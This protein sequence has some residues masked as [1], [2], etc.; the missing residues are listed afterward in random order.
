MVFSCQY[1]DEQLRRAEFL[2]DEPGLDACDDIVD[3]RSRFYD[4][5]GYLPKLYDSI[6]FDVP[7][8][9]AAERY[10]MVTQK[11]IK[12]ETDHVF[13]GKLQLLLTHFSAQTPEKTLVLCRKRYDVAQNEDALMT[14]KPRIPCKMTHGDLPQADREASMFGFKHGH[15]P[16]LISSFKLGGRGLNINGVA[17]IIFF[18][19]PESFDEYKLSLGRVGRVGNAGK[20]KT[21][22]TT[23]D[24]VMDPVLGA[25]LSRNNEPLPDALVGTAE[26]EASG[27][28][29]GDTD[30]GAD[31][32]EAGGD[33]GGAGGDARGA[34]AGGDA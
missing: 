34:E 10:T 29:G 15:V 1:S 24:T 12:V 3:P 32:A 33:A 22:Y 4:E 7:D 17:S 13:E 6:D 31:G 20:A 27:G 8:D 21:F 11:F 19:A 9:D 26:V 14:H 30:G 18:D 25:F 28:A 23:N 5:A 2:I 16:V